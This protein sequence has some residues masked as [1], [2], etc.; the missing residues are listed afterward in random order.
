MIME[1]R[2][3]SSFFSVVVRI[4]FIWACACQFLK[5][6]IVSLRICFCVH[7]IRQHIGWLSCNVLQKMS[8]LKVSK[9]NKYITFIFNN[10]IFYYRWLLFVLF[11]SC[12]SWLKWWMG[13]RSFWRRILT[14]TLKFDKRRPHQA[15]DF[16]CWALYQTKFNTNLTKRLKTHL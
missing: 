12:Q 4:W 8:C 9:Q 7:W 10:Y 5:L 6:K 2:C 11:S 15:S 13:S 3:P 16:N 14:M 1:T